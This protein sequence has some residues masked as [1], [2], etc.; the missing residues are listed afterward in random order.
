MLREPDPFE[1]RNARE[2]NVMQTGR[3][4]TIHVTCFA[5]PGDQLLNIERIA[6]RLS[7]RRTRNRWCHTETLRQLARLLC[8]QWQQMHRRVWP[9]I[10]DPRHS[11][12]PGTERR[13]QSC[14]R[15]RIL[16]C[17][18]KAPRWFIRPV[19]VVQHQNVHLFVAHAPPYATHRPLA[20]KL[21][22]WKLDKLSCKC[23]K[24]AT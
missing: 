24:I 1:P 20:R 19:Q 3:V 18:Q 21:L 8:L 4:C 9:Q 6:A 2:D 7:H 5:C 14:L 12:W 22:I 13:Q 11:R 23:C 16:K 10:R 17:A 15:T